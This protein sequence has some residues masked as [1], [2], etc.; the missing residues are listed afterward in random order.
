M[1][2]TITQNNVQ[3]AYL[4]ILG[5]ATVVAALAA[6]FAAVFAGSSRF[7]GVV[8]TEINPDHAIITCQTHFSAGAVFHGVEQR[9]D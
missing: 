7:G 6:A 8:I 2:E 9:D 1:R 3:R 5:V 4:A